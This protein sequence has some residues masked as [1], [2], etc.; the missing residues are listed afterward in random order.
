MTLSR[1]FFSGRQ[2]RHLIWLFFHPYSKR[3]I[4]LDVGGHT[5]SY[6]E[7]EYAAAEND[8]NQRVDRIV[9]EERKRKHEAAIYSR[10]QRVSLLLCPSRL[11]TVNN[12]ISVVE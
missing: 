11:D 1:S 9:K 6:A 2:L 5:H 8:Y 7:G 10:L 12:R 4:V 3:W